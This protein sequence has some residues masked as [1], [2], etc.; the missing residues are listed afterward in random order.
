MFFAL[1]AV[2]SKFAF[3]SFKIME[4]VNKWMANCRRCNTTIPKLR[5]QL[6]YANGRFFSCNFRPLRYV[7]SSSL[8][9]SYQDLSSDLLEVSFQC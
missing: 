1:E 2:F 9:L 4:N 5:E 7:S 6:F 3:R 8:N